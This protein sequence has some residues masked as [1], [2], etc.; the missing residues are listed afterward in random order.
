MSGT[1]GQV[2]LALGQILQGVGQGL[3]VGDLKIGD[4][5]PGCQFGEGR[6]H[7]VGHTAGA[8]GFRGKNLLGIGRYGKCH[9]R[10]QGGQR[11]FSRHDSSLNLCLT[12]ERNFIAASTELGKLDRVSGRGVSV[13]HSMRLPVQGGIAGQPAVDRCAGRQP[14]N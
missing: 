11:E 12:S 14:E 8:G 9:G 1:A 3:A 10:R 7:S 2:G 13:L 6:D 5:C 4:A